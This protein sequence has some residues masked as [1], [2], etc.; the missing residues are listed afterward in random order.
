MPTTSTRMAWVTPHNLSQSTR[1]ADG[2]H[3]VY[4]TACP[5]ALVLGNERKEQMTVALPDHQTHNHS[6]SRSLRRCMHRSTR[7]SRYQAQPGSRGAY[8]TPTV[9]PRLSCCTLLRL[10]NREAPHRH[11]ALTAVETLPQPQLLLPQHCSCG[12]SVAG[13]A[14]AQGR[15]DSR[16]VL[17]AGRT[18]HRALPLTPAGY[19][20]SPW[21]GHRCCCHAQ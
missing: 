17:N 4:D 8:I 13:A 12:G 3:R 7:H 6:L 15:A 5:S 9:Q 16:D 11:T 2:V 21:S 10:V 1:G 19:H 20:C 14:A 18:A